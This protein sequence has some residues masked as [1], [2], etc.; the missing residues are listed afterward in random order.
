MPKS[1]TGERLLLEHQPFTATPLLRKIFA[2]KVAAVVG[3][4]GGGS[5]VA[6]FLAAFGFHEIIGIDDQRVDESNRF[7][8]PNLGWIDSLLGLRKTL[9]VKLRVKLVNRTVKF[10]GINARVP[11]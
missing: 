7:A 11:E 9:S 1:T 2:G 8:S 10:T 5:Q 4:S 3:L 6:P